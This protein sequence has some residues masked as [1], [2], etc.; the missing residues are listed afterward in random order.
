MSYEEDKYNKFIKKIDAD[1]V[2]IEDSVTSGNSTSLL[3]NEQK[4][5]LKEYCEFIL[6][7]AESVYDNNYDENIKKIND[8][9]KISEPLANR[10]MYSEISKFIYN[11]SS[12]KRLFFSMEVNKILSICLEKDCEDNVYLFLV[13]LSDHVDIAILQIDSL[14][15]LSH[16][17]INKIQGTQKELV[18]KIEDDT[19]KIEN[20]Y[21]SKVR[22]INENINI[23]KNEFKENVESTEKGH[24][25]ILGIFS[26][27]IITFTGGL[28][29]LGSILSS[30]NSASP[31][32]IAFVTS[33]V[34]I[35]FF[36]IICYLCDF[37]Y[38]IVNIDKKN[39]S[40]I[41]VNLR[42]NFNRFLITCIIITTILY[43]RK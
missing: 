24:I 41:N 30:M 5:I 38:K 6:I 12:D 42:H 35:I 4:K 28:Q 34:G 27:I 19:K 8:I 3:V 9:L 25:A 17:I 18:D 37:I 15:R 13:K 39:N 31:Y 43:F 22:E 11:L 2:D 36:N 23:N 40:V 1:V 26:S 33:M 7:S 20:V 32:R 21:E 14:E 10:V 29:V 16:N